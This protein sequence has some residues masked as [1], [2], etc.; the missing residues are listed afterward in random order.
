MKLLEIMIPPSIDAPL[1]ISP[2]QTLGDQY[3]RLFC[4]GLLRGASDDHFN[5]RTF[6]LCQRC[7][8][9][10]AGGFLGGSADPSSRAIV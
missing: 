3:S 1:K 4:L 10:G 5:F 9:L 6:A 8:A 7:F 2:P